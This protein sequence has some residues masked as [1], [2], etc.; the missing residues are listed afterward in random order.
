MIWNM[1][2]PPSTSS[3]ASST[4]SSALPLSTKG[5]DVAS[6]RVL[7]INRGDGGG[8]GGGGDESELWMKDSPEALL[9]NV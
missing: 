8:V 2:A 5:D 3:A 6:S 4:S 7:S 1:N 9:S